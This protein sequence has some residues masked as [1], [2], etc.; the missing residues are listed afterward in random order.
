ML[1]LSGAENVGHVDTS[2]L[3]SKGK[4]LGH[5][6]TSNNYNHQ[7]SI[8]QSPLIDYKTKSVEYESTWTTPKCLVSPNQQDQDSSERHGRHVHLVSSEQTQ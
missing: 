7:I 6:N 5:K 3:V 2:F 4:S 8:S 1:N